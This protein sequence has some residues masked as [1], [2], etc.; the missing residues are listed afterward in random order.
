MASRATIRPASLGLGLHYLL[1]AGGGLGLLGGL[2]RAG[3][4]RSRPGL[5]S[6]PLRSGGR[7][8]HD[9]GFF[10]PRQAASGTQD[11]RD[12]SGRTLEPLV[13]RARW[14]RRLSRTRERGDP[15]A[16]GKLRVARMGARKRRARASSCCAGCGWWFWRNHDQSSTAADCWP[17]ANPSLLLGVRETSAQIA[18]DELASG[19]LTDG[20]VLGLRATAGCEREVSRTDPGFRSSGSRWRR[21]K[22]ISEISRI[23]LRGSPGGSAPTPLVVGSGGNPQV[24]TGRCRSPGPR[25]HSCNRRR[26]PHRR[27]ARTSLSSPR[28]PAWLWFLG[29]HA[30]LGGVIAS[31][32]RN[33][34]SVP[35]RS[36]CA[37]RAR[38]AR[39]PRFL[40][41]SGS[42]RR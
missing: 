9:P 4:A 6:R 38:A 41:R 29:S 25:G 30:N 8:R 34:T 5:T 17:T 32:T 13:R 23:A 19:A 40:R 15:V 14:I 2:R 26:G 16:D 31:M 39:S 12:L 7:H 35:R 18:Y 28:T 36:A 11:T 37:R 1:L 21:S 10:A 20:A 24:V 33:A 3:D 22:S 42:F 27:P